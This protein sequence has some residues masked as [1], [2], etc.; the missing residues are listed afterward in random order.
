M[1]V[2]RFEFGANWRRF[3][4]TVD[5]ARISAAVNSLRSMLG[6]ESLQGKRFLDVGSGSGLFSL[7]AHRLGG[8][9]HSFDYDPQSVA[10]TEEIRRRFGGESPPW[11]IEQGSA[12]DEGYLS[13]LPRFDIVYSWGV[14]HHTGEMWRAIDLVSGLV[15]SEGLLWIAI[16]ND[17][18]DATERWTM[19]KRLYQ[20][21]PRPLGP[22][23][24][25][26]AGAA[27]ALRKAWSTLLT[28]T[29]RLATLRNPL[30]P[31]RRAAADVS[32]PDARGMHRWHDLVDWVGG[33]PFE[34][35]RPE[36][37]FRFLRERGF[38]L[39]ELKTC[40]GGLGCNEYLFQ[41]THQICECE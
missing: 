24:C 23:L 41:R 27:I 40:G 39:L 22:A 11:T 20:R 21:L 17:Q 30:V 12:L 8:H 3:L 32:R 15:A 25:V 14:L 9:V 37:V 19:I 35:A 31:L 33:W 38:S 26:L 6:A 29:L 18:G 2:D 7:A 1:S 34:V 5:E 13:R 36:E 10:C 16:Y 28:A 4:E